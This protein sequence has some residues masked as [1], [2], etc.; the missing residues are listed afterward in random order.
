MMIYR[1]RKY[2]KVASVGTEKP[3]PRIVFTGP[4][5]NEEIDA[6]NAKN[7]RQSY[8]GENKTGRKS[9]EPD[10]FTQPGQNGPGWR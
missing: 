6:K 2:K 9:V 3:N 4:R 1:N 10:P 8:G 5:R 7:G